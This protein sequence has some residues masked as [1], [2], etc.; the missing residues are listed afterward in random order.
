MP[1]QVAQRG[2]TVGGQTYAQAETVADEGSNVTG[3]I[4]VAD[5][6][7]DA[8]V[9][10]AADVSELSLFY[11]STTAEITVE[12]NSGSSPDDT[13]TVKPNAPFLWTADDPFANPFTADLTDLFI[14]NASGASASV[15]I[16]AAADVTP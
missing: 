1:T 7:T 13:F 15:T 4:T 3:P 2:V 16:V 11:L 14:T 6:S 8:Q 12:T 10:L 5:G 9:N